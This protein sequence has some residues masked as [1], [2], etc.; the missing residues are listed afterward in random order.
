[1]LQLVSLRGEGVR[2]TVSFF[3][4]IPTFSAKTESKGGPVVVELTLRLAAERFTVS[5]KT[6]VCLLAGGEQAGESRCDVP[7]G[8][9]PCPM[10]GHAVRDPQDHRGALPPRLLWHPALEHYPASLCAALHLLPLPLCHLPL[11]DLV[12]RLPEGRQVYV[13]GRDWCISLLEKWKRPLHVSLFCLSEREKGTPCEINIKCMYF[14]YISRLTGGG[15]YLK[16]K[17]RRVT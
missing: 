7:A 13:E 15:V 9:Q 16:E 10:G 5:L 2:R 17:G 6:P 8:V 1:M 14:D 11:Q 3:T 4:F 12:Q